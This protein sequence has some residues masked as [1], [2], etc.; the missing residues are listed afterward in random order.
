MLT[1]HKVYWLTMSNATLDF[2]LLAVCQVLIFSLL[3]YNLR[4]YFGIVIDIYVFQED[5]R[6]NNNESRS[7]SVRD[8]SFVLQED[9]MLFFANC[10]CFA[11]VV[12]ACC[13]VADVEF[14]SY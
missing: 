3:P 11:G 2:F 4:H 6:R 5:S 8:A 10:F 12:I 13:V 1:P 9:P 14:H 7:L